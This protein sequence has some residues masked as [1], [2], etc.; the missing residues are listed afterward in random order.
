MHEAPSYLT[1]IRYAIV[2]GM[3]SGTREFWAPSLFI[4]KGIS[5]LVRRLCK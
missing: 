1:R 5:T 2:A 4:V 3:K